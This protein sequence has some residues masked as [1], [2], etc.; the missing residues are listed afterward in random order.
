MRHRLTL[1]FAFLAAAFG[2][3]CT[4]LP[5]HPVKSM[6]L[7]PDALNLPYEDVRIRTEDGQT[8]AGWYIPATEN[9]EAPGHGLTL[10]FLHGNAGNISHRLESISVFNQLGLAQLIIDYRGFGESTG[11]PSVHGTILDAEAALAW[12]KEHKQLGPEQIVMF[13]RSLGGGVAAALAARVAPRA[14]ILE[15]TF[16]TLY[17]VA[18]DLYPMLPVGL[19]LPQDYDTPGALRKLRVPLLVVHSPDDDFVSFRFG[20]ELHDAYS[21]PKSFLQI[22]GSHNRGYVDDKQNYVRGLEQFFAGLTK[23]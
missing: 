3:G 14:L 10:L 12:L 11:K 21:G 6:G 2:A 23:R 17:A 5:F 13:G 22:K 7:T 19:F 16:T 4:S 9:E 20:K 15:S 1:L 18:K 8:I